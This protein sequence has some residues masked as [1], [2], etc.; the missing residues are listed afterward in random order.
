MKTL[1]LMLIAFLTMAVMPVAAD[2]SQ[3]GQYGQYGGGAPAQTIIVDKMVARNVTTKGGVVKYVDNFAP[4]DA[5]F[6][7]GERVYFQV[8]VKNTGSTSIGN[9]VVADILPDYVDAAEGPG[10]YNP[11]TRTISWAYSELKSGEERV[12]KIVVQIKPQ[13]QLP[14]DRGNFCLVNKAK[15]Q[16]GAAYDDDTSQFCVEKKVEMTKSGKPAQVPQ[17]GPE[18]G[19]ILGALNVLGLSAGIYLRK[20]V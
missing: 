12:E 20:R 7:A 15:A 1:F 8:K 6:K 5:R 4:S 10:D 9:V 19:L 2:V 13:A 3:Y 17:A 16:S 14:A 18:F 11:K